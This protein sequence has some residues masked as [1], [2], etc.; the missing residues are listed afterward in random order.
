MSE[1]IRKQIDLPKETVKELKVLAAYADS[2]VK[3]YI[4]T[5]VIQH[6]KANKG[7]K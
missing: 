7:K 2:N 6:V 4:E 3:K 1:I 5:I